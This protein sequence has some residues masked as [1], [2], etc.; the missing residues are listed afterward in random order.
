MKPAKLS[1]TL[2]DYL[3]TIYRLEQ[4]K[5]VA[6]A[7]DIARMQGVARSTVTAALQSLAQKGLIHYEPYEA[8]TLTAKGRE[9]AVQFALRHRIL[10]EFL[11]D[12]LGLEPAAAAQTAC[13][14][15]HAVEPKV[16]ERFV[17]FLAFLTQHDPHGKQWL[18]EFK[19]FAPQGGRSRACKKCISK[20][21]AELHKTL[22]ADQAA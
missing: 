14:M 17:C 10:S 2:E 11:S 6:R 18:D 4:T 5:P 1:A 22:N 7:R 12:V 20:Y 3:Q 16:L 13:Q 15:E 9:A 19:K 21:L 8:I